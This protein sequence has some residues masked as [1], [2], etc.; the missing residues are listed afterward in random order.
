MGTRANAWFSYL[1]HCTSPVPNRQNLKRLD[2]PTHNLF[3][4]RLLSSGAR[5]ADPE[6]ADWFFIPVSSQSRDWMRPNMHA[7]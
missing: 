4:Q 7:C 3:W 1:P 6:Q 2:R 5:V